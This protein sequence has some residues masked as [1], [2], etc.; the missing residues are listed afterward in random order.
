[1]FETW[2]LKVKPRYVAAGLFALLATVWGFS[3]PA[4]SIGLES[5]E[6]VLFAAFRYDVAAVLLVGYGLLRTR[7]WYPTANNDLLAVAAG[8]VFLVSANAMLFLGQQTVPAG[9]AAVMQ[10]LVPIA[11]TLDR[12]SVV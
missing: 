9:V 4:I 7:N 10:S 2:P 5:L 1:M 11:T 6:P 12:K 8:G 3:F